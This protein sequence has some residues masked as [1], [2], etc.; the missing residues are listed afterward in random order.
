MKG[1]ISIVYNP[2]KI[3]ICP[4]N[5]LLPPPRQFWSSGSGKTRQKIFLK[6]RVMSAGKTNVGCVWLEDREAFCFSTLRGLEDFLDR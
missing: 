1:A 4:V 3:H 6:Y 5:H 2:L